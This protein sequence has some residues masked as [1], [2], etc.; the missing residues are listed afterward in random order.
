MPRLLALLIAFLAIQAGAAE[1]HNCLGE[2]IVGVAPVRHP[3]PVCDGSGEVPDPEPPVFAAAEPGDLEPRAVP[4]AG[5]QPREV[6][7]RVTAT[8]HGVLHHGSGVLVQVTPVAG[9]LLTNWHVVRDAPRG[10]TV[11]WPDGS[12]VQGRVM[13]H[14]SEWDL[15]AV[16]VARPTIQPVQIAASAPRLG[17]HLTMAGY[18]P[19]GGYLEQHGSVT[20]YLSPVRS[21]RREFVEMRA[22]AR[23]GDSGGPM[24]NDDGELAGVLF[25]SVDGRTIGSCSTRL[26]SFLAAAI[27][28]DRGKA[29]ACVGGACKAGRQCGGDGHNEVSREVAAQ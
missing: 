14:D 13:A 1:C 16:A 6:V 12:V 4:R 26:R 2:R 5:G 17:D 28:A 24:F 11:L 29:A 27:E 21:R 10:I 9:I 22:Q 18:G 7:A 19:S 23:N 3:C 20:G 15:A 25:G 8:G